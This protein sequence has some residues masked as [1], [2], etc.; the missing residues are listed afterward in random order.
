MKRLFLFTILLTGIVVLSACASVF[1]AEP[2]RDG[3]VEVVL[4]DNRFEPKIIKVKAGQTVEIVLRNEGKKVH[5]FMIGRDV[6]VENDLTEGFATDFFA[7]VELEFE[8][9][10]MIMGLP[11]GMGEMDMGDSDSGMDGMEMEAPAD[12]HG[13]NSEMGDMGNDSGGMDMAESE[14]DHGDN[15]ETGDMGSDSGGMDMEE[16][17]GEHGDDEHAEAD[18]G[19]FGAFQISQ[20]EA[21][22]A[23][24]MVMIDPTMI[25]ASEETIIRMTIPADMVG[26]WEF[27]CF[28][29]R[30]QHYDDGMRGTFIVEP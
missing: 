24:I 9:P 30:G 19:E 17:T 15:S 8:G 27:G 28:Q 13:D 25:P 23:G 3:R 10:G 2:G 11:E 18:F 6:Q 20:L 29:E 5:E 22:H 12:D 21:G 1:A 26:T 14:D 16:P 4:F 7:G